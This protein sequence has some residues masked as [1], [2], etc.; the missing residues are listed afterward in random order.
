MRRNILLLL[1]IFMAGL[2]T[3]NFAQ[4]RGSLEQELNRLKITINRT[5]AFINFLPDNDLK[6]TL[7]INLQKANEEYGKAV[8][9][10]NSDRPVLARQHIK[11]AYQYL[12]EIESLVK[13]HPVF[14]IKFRERLDLKIQQAEEIVQASQ[15][16]D[17]MH[18]LNRAKFFRQKAYMSFRG[19][20]SYNALEYYR[21]AVFFAEKAIQIADARTDD[22]QDWRG[23]LSETEM[24]LERA[25]QLADNTSNP[26]LQ[27]MIE[28]SNR[29]MQEIRTLYSDNQTNTAKRKLQILHRSL[30]RI[31]DIAEDIPLQDNDR[32]SVDIQTLK[33]TIQELEND[34]QEINSP[35]AKQL[36]RRASNLVRTIEANQRERNLLLA[37]QRVLAAN[38]LILQIYRVIENGSIDSPNELQHQIERTRQNLEELQSTDN[39]VSVAAELLNL[40]KTN[41]N[42]AEKA[43]SRGNRLQASFHLKMANR[44][45]LKFNRLRLLQSTTEMAKTSVESDLQRLE[46]LLNRIDSSKHA[47]E[48]FSIRY[49]NA[50]KLY[51]LAGRAFS[52]NDFR[53]CHELT[54]MGII[55][56][57]N[58]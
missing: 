40:I 32:L 44:L 5:E 55:L 50:R 41:L 13:N 38:R 24:L 14:K 39:S 42:N 10:A 31:I 27:N 30:Y 48:D 18:M 52:E 49:E 26:Q 34:L 57:T 33:Y 4:H 21:L 25:R 22:I 23:L 1:L 37:R 2:F 16:P 47:D 56:I 45:I 19:D 54:Q 12:K 58:N 36:Y 29:E 17:A 53:L 20:Q 35:A 15:K 43:N 9:F 6:K 51:E 3:N 46:G 7:L 28:K 8:E 11:L